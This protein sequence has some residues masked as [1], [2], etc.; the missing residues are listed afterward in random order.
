MTGPSRADRHTVRLARL[1]TA[2]WMVVGGVVLGLASGLLLALFAADR[3]IRVIGLLVVALSVVQALS[4]P[5]LFRVRF[6][7]GS[8]QR[9][10]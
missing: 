4:L 2:R 3:P 9:P 1:R 5:A 10:R 8:A 6:P 7:T